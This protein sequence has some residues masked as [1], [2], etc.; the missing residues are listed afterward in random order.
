M[1]AKNI[2]T[3]KSVTE[4][5]YD[6]FYLSRVHSQKGTQKSIYSR[7]FAAEGGNNVLPGTILKMMHLL[8]TFFTV[9]LPLIIQ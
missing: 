1:H 8:M 4:C 7:Y 9:F 5:K 6:L 3:L 2:A